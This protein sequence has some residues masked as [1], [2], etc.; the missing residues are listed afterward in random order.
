MRD[1]FIAAAADHKAGRLAAAEQGYR[2]VLAADPW[3]PD[4]LH[5][6]GVLAYQTGQNEAAVAL[7]GRA[8]ALHANAPSYHSNLGLAL[9]DLGRLEAAAEAFGRAISLNPQAAAAHNNLGIVFTAQGRWEEALACSARALD[10]APGFADAFAN[11]GHVRRQQGELEAAITQYREAI[12]LQP[13]FAEA[14]TSL[15]HALLQSGAFAEGWAE[16][17]WRWQTRSML[18][19]RRDF[20][21]PRWRG[22]Q[23]D[24]RVLLLHA[25]QGFGDTLQFCRFAAAA[26]ARGCRVILEVQKP[27]VRLLTGLP[28][29]ATVLGRGEALPPFDLHAPLLSLPQALGVTLETLPEPQPYLQP[30]QAL[31]AHWR[32]RLA[33]PEAGRLVGLVWAGS[34]RPAHAGIDRRRSIAPELLAPLFQASGIAFVSLQKD[35]PAM[36]AGLPLIEPMP[37]VTD[38]ADTAA[39]IANLDLVI[40]V[41]T[42]VAHLAGAMGKPVWMLNRFDSCWRWPSMGR[43]SPRRASPGRVSPGRVSPWYPTLRIYQQPVPGD[44]ESPIAAVAGDLNRFISIGSCSKS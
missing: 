34:H 31:A 22:E 4:A 18:A 13:D 41:D 24:G 42:A 17:E 5:M 8:I 20:A 2:R 25:E 29:V 39:L 19:G 44:W 3:Q 7:I 27:L 11:I 38:F 21:Q 37:E 1:V 40:T 43:A 10:L 28:G 15:A 6:L 35:G 36:P 26:A 33:A 30:D 14:H 9:K 12:A 32:A 16:Y 23:G